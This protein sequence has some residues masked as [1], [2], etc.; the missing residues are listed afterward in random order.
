ME[1]IQSNMLRQAIEKAQKHPH[2]KQRLN[3][4]SIEFTG[5]VIRVECE[6]TKTERQRKEKNGDSTYIGAHL[7]GLFWH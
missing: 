3:N 4:I 7:C 2:Q 6:D 5:E 1:I